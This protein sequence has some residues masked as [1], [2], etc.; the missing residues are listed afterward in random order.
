M[1]RLFYG[2][3]VVGGAFAVLFMAYGTQYAFGVFFSALLDEF[4]WSR[5]SLSGIFSLYA[6]LYCVIGLP[7]GRLTDLWGP[8]V[9]IAIGGAVLGLGLAGM[10]RV[11]ALWHPYLF[12]GVVAALGMSTAY[13]PCNATVVKW[14]VRQRG[15]A[16]GVASSGGSLGTFALPPVAAALVGAVGWRWAYV[17]FGAGIFLILNLVA[18]VMRRDPELLGLSPDG[19]P[20]L[21][22]AAGQAA[23]ETQ[24]PLRMAIRT[25]AFWLIFGIFT[26]TWIP[27]FLP[28]VHIV[29]FARDLGMSPLVASTVLSALGIAAVVG[30]L[31]MGAVSDRIGRKP[32]LAL[33]IALQAAAFLGFTLVG[34]L[35]SL[36]LVALGFGFSYGAVST[37]FPAIVGDFFG[38]EQAGSLVGFLFA[39]AGSMAAWGPLFAGAIYDATGAYTWAFLLSAASNGAA[40]ALLALAHPPRPRPAH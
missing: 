34:G 20:G 6:F 19:G 16:L 38:R 39:L 7:A 35:P 25:G 31:V 28:L 29:P 9:V 3:V 5:A 12:Y 37:L 13:V 36:Y 24:W 15:L 1:P 2:W 30:R 40:L 8:R 27:V 10:S 14:F 33:V 17:L 23:A 4:G 32:A 18:T 21:A 11:S 22:T 26:A